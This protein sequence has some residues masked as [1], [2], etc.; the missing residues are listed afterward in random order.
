MTLSVKV[1]QRVL[2]PE[3][4]ARVIHEGQ[5]LLDNTPTINVEEA[6]Y[7]RL[8]RSCRVGF[9]QRDCWLVNV[10]MAAWQSH[11]ADWKYEVTSMDRPQFTRYDEGCFFELHQDV[12]RARSVDIRKVSMSLQLS[13][14]SSY[15]G[16][17]LEFE[18][19]GAMVRVDGSRELG[20][21]IMYPSYVRH[22]VTT[23]ERGCR[24]SLVAWLRGSPFA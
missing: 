18:D 8:G 13:D 10:L 24:L 19:D 23:V 14:P 7:S 2:S 9:F 1:V 5:Q 3:D 12:I 20:A 6:F 4:C 21:L 15:E 16:G 17:D 22:R 11:S